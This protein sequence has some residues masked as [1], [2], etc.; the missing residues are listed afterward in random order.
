MKMIK[1][2]TTELGNQGDGSSGRLEGA[3]VSNRKGGKASKLPSLMVIVFLAGLS[4]FLYPFVSNM[5]AVH[6][7]AQAI[8]NYDAHVTHLSPAQI[9]DELQRAQVYNENLAGDPVHDPFIAGSGMA[10]P[11]NYESVLN[12]DGDGL[13]GYIKIPAI[14]VDLPIYHGTSD[15]VLEKGVGHIEQTALP[16]GGAG[17]HAVLSGHTGLP[18][19]KLFTDL[20]K[21]KEGD[22]FIITV[23]NQKFTYQVDR[24]TV[25]LPDQI[26]QLQA[27]PGEDHIT[28]LTC[29]PYGINDHR[30]L[31]RGMRIPN[32]D[33]V[34]IQSQTFPWRKAMIAGATVLTGMALIVRRKMKHK[35]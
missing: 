28:L 25:I 21:L 35:K 12:I 32:Q 34:Q 22:V 29:T 9:T 26:D 13:M 8:Q 5:V 11:E 10:L 31:V 18:S 33:D 3:A 19:A 6:N 24:I 17:T 27:V 30:L 20:T 7:A 4:V 15:A 1:V 23:L 14:N 16:V 2:R